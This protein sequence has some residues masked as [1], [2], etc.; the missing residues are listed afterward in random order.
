MIVVDIEKYGDTLVEQTKGKRRGPEGKWA[1]YTDLVATHIILGNR[2]EFRL[3]NGIAIKL[4]RGYWTEELLIKE[5]L[6]ENR[7]EM[8]VIRKNAEEALKEYNKYC[9][10][11]GVEDEVR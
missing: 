8:E 11:C 3:H 5:G 2:V 9:K 6:L 1:K 10:C 4:F 7:E